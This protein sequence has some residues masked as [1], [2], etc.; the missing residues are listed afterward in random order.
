MACA[1]WMVSFF[2]FVTPDPA[3]LDLDLDNWYTWR[4]LCH[5]AFGRLAPPP[6]AP[7]TKPAGFFERPSAMFPPRLL[8]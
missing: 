7:Q 2:W 5:A 1:S 4:P 8:V 3:P 6:Q